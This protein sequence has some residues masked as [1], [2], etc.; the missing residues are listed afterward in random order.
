[1]YSPEVIQELEKESISWTSESGEEQRSTRESR[2]CQMRAL[3][4][5][6]DGRVESSEARLRAWR[7]S[8]R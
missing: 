7:Y 4:Q 3:S 1:M 6:V 2:Q 5:V 8:Q